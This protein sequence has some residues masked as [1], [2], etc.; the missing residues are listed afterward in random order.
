MRKKN[1]MQNKIHKEISEAVGT[2]VVYLTTTEALQF[3]ERVNISVTLPT[4][5]SWCRK[6]RIGHQLGG[7]HGHWVVDQKKLEE[8]LA[9]DLPKS[10]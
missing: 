10:E 6:F 7:L 2:E 8:F 3:A 1:R 9:G 5:I 4:I